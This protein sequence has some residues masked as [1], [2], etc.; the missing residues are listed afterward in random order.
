MAKQWANE[1]ATQVRLQHSRCLPDTRGK[2]C[3]LDNTTGRRWPVTLPLDQRRGENREHLAEVERMRVALRIGIQ[4]CLRHKV[5]PRLDH[6]R[7]SGAVSSFFLLRNSSLD[8]RTCWYLPLIASTN[9]FRPAEAAGGATSK[10]RS[11][12][13]NSRRFRESKP[14]TASNILTCQTHPQAERR[15]V[16]S[17][18]GSSS[19][20]AA[21]L[22]VSSRGALR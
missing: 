9:C 3:V 20:F 10:A 22:P 11:A 18:H 14:R 5:G 13:T 17:R 1:N 2:V 7:D 8:V 16:R 12:K 4:E 21:R 19:R 15:T 6:D